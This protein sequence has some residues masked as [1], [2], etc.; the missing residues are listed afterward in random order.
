MA[1]AVL[2][3]LSRANKGKYKDLAAASA[4]KKIRR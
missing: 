2:E 1:Y 4:R 3:G